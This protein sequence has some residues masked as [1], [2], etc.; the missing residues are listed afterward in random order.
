M[1]SHTRRNKP[2]TAPRY[3]NQ[4]DIMLTPYRQ[5]TYRSAGT[6][7]CYSAQTDPK[8]RTHA[9]NVQRE[10]EN[11][12]VD[13]TCCIE[14]LWAIPARNDSDADVGGCE[15]ENIMWRTTHWLPHK[16]VVFVVY[17]RHWDLPN[18]YDKWDLQR[19]CDSG[20]RGEDEPNTWM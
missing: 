20:Q 2:L 10:M 9:K 8:S 14:N 13:S 3:K 5:T 17:V 18:K 15:H 1:F 6:R 11:A 4:D 19:S 12:S 16:C 7:R